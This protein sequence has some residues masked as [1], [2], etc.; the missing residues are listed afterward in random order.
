MK[1]RSNR[2]TPVPIGDTVQN[3]FY[4][5]FNLIPK[6]RRQLNFKTIEMAVSASFVI[7]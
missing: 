7:L 1:D 3:V 4:M 5:V 2:L 6:G